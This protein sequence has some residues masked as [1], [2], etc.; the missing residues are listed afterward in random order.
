MNISLFRFFSDLT[1]SLTSLI[2]LGSRPV[3]GSSRSSIVGSLIS[4]AA[5]HILCFMPFENLPTLLSNHS[6]M[7]TSATASSILFFRSARGTPRISA[8][9]MS[10]SL[11]VRD[12]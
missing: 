4:A 5:M 10:A 9:I 2:P 7:R 3:V 11:G 12:G 1:M 6:L 8:T